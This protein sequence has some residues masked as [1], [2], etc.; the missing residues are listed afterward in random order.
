MG[1]HISSPHIAPCF[2]CDL[3]FVDFKSL[4]NHKQSHG[5]TVEEVSKPANIIPSTTTSAT[6]EV[7][8]E[9]NKRRK[10]V[11][12][13]ALSEMAVILDVADLI[14]IDSTLIERT[15][16]CP[17][18]NDATVGELS[19]TEKDNRRRKSSEEHQCKSCGK[20]FTSEKDLFHHSVLEHFENWSFAEAEKNVKRTQTGW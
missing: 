11:K 6:T 13:E 17:P 9:P 8:S 15:K 4:L 3:M 5:T 16:D 20:V 14:R 7:R 12:V 2:D 10:K 18:S 1:D 19:I